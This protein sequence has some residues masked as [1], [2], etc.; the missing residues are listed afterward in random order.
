MS[1]RVEE[2]T[3]STSDLAMM[4]F[5]DR[6]PD[7]RVEIS[8]NGA[9]CMR[10]IFVFCVELCVLGLASAARTDTLDVTSITVDQFEWVRERMKRV[11]IL[12]QLRSAPMEPT[13]VIATNAETWQ[14]APADQD[15][16]L[17]ECKLIDGITGVM[18][19]V[20]FSPYMSES[21]CKTV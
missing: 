4:L 12:A 3:G 6:P 19:T 8:V 18:H 2:R 16:H 20:T 13:G 5:S 10:D 11:S 15:L 17:Y 1:L 21:S 7:Q 9:T 14:Y